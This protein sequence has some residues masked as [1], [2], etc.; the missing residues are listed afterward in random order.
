V[1]R[2][3]SG[4][5]PT[6]NHN[7]GG[8]SSGGESSV[9]VRQM[10][11]M[12]MESPSAAS[13]RIVGHCESVREVPPPPVAVESRADRFVTAGVKRLGEYGCVYVYMYVVPGEIS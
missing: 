11:L 10:P 13:L 6:L 8:P 7:G 1:R 5:T 4:E 9:M 12:E 3:V 2:R